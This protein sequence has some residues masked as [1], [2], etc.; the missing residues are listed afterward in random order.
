MYK[1]N[2]RISWLHFSQFKSLMNAY[3]KSNIICK[4]S[5]FSRVQTRTASRLC[6]HAAYRQQL[7]N[8]HLKILFF[9]LRSKYCGAGTYLSLYSLHSWVVKLSIALIEIDQKLVCRK[10]FSCK[11]LT[12]NFT[13][14]VLTILYLSMRDRGI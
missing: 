4:P 8:A 13:P 6:G 12:R 2:L 11:F 3:R 10:N 1:K 9:N 14:A 5:L 7:N